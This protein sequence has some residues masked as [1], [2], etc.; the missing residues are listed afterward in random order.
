MFEQEAELE[1]HNSGILPLLLVIGLVVAVVG[2]GGH[3]IW[4]SSKGLSNEQAT[5]VVM[6]AL[7]S[8]GAAA[9]Q[10]YTGPVAASVNVHPRDPNYRLMEKAGWLKL[11]KGKGPITPI[12]LTP[13]GE[14]QLEAIKGV[15]KTQEKDNTTAYQV[16]IAERQ[17][18]S[19]SKITMQA[20]TRAVVEYSWKW[21]PNELGEVF[22]ASG[23]LVK[24]FS[25]WER[26]TL[27][28]KYN[29]DFYHGSPTKVVLPL[30]KTDK[31]WTIASD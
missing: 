3:Y 22:E 30:M 5:G 10:F 17:L 26:A 18:V 29:A 6:A 13:K 1:K 7:R 15:H 12:K 16:P 19:I 20:P 23:P 31:G 4:E 21:Q 14:Q 28:Q 8:Q 2:V 11:E 25:S 24:S 27:I 9:I